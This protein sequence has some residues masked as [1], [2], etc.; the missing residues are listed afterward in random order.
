M[1]SILRLVVP[2]TCSFGLLV[3]F[4]ALA[5]DGMKR[6]ILRQADL[7]GAPG[8]EVV[9]SIFEIQPGTTVP[10]H[11]HHGIETGLV[12]EGAMIQYPGEKPQMLATG[13]P[14][15]IL[16]EEMHTAYKVVD[17]KPLKI[18]TVHIVDK[19]KPLFDGVKQGSK[20]L[21]P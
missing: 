10:W 2:L 3:S 1:Y 13:T 9:S 12:L 17:N 7:S 15:F 8:M 21:Q 19:S 4:P 14:V 16:R 5:Q 11:F 20:A 6:T 18:F